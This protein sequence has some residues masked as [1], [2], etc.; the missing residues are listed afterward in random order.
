MFGTIPALLAA[1]GTWPAT[2]PFGPETGEGL[3]SLVL[4]GLFV[5]VVLGGLAWGLRLLFGPGGPWREPDDDTAESR[6][7]KDG[8][9]TVR[10]KQ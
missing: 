7:L 5:V 4:T 10:Q 1:S 6:N 3:W 9:N 8:R 2:W